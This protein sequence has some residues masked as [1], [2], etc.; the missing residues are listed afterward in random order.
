MDGLLTGE[1]G[2]IKIRLE[3]GRQWV[4][5]L[6]DTT[7]NRAFQDK[8]EILTQRNLLQVFPGNRR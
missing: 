1:D 2:N 6:K 7:E 3:E 5:K 4:R 8:I